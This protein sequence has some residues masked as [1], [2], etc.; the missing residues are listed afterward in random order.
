MKGSFFF[1]LLLFFSFTATA[2]KGASVYSSCKAPSPQ[3]CDFEQLAMVTG[4]DKHCYLNKCWADKKGVKVRKI[5][6]QKKYYKK[7]DVYTWIIE[8][9]CIPSAKEQPV[10]TDLGDGTF[11]YKYSDR[12]FRGTP[13]RCRCLPVAAQIDTPTGWIA[14]DQLVEGD[15]VYSSNKE[16]EKIVVPIKWTNKVPVLT[17]HEMVSLDLADGRKIVVT[18]AHPSSTA[19]KTIAEFEINEPL[20]GSTV[21]G[22]V[23]VPYLDLYTYDILP[24]S[25]TGFYWVNG[26]L[27]GS[28]LKRYE[29][30][31]SN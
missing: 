23:Q 5:G 10:L 29:S 26:I 15:F 22:K 30:L 8:D 18:S 14:I 31:V 16:G 17:D 28:T 1:S 21:I 2:V 27:I 6:Y 19:N 25:E 3:D 7:S 13:N 20:D 12:E 9:V 11:L 24:L 4:K